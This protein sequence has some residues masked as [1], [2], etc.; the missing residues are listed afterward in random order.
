MRWGVG[1]H[2]WNIRACLYLKYRQITTHGLCWLRSGGKAANSYG[3]V[4]GSSPLPHADLCSRDLAQGCRN[5]APRKDPECNKAS[6]LNVCVSIFSLNKSGGS[7]ET[8]V[9]RGRWSV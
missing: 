1:R 2:A 6:D 5:Q 7:P 3:L 9:F 8:P 4:F